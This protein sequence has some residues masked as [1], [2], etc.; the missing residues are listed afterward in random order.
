MWL[1]TFLVEVTRIS[2]RL[3]QIA[4]V[5][6]P[7]LVGAVNPHISISPTSG[8]LGVT[9]FFETYTGFTPNGG[10]TEYDTYPNGGINIHTLTANNSGASS[11]SFV[12]QSQTGNYSAYAVDNASGI[13]SNTITYAVHVPAST[14]TITSIAPGSPTASSGNQNVAV[15]GSQFQSGLTVTVGFPN[16]G[17]STLSGSQIVNVTASSFGMAINFN[18]IAGSYSIRVNNP[19]GGQSNTYGFN[20]GAAASTPT[21]TSISP[22][23]VAVNQPTTVTVNGSNFQSGFSAAVITSVGTYPIASAG[24]MFISSTQVKVQV[25][26]GGTPPF[27]ATLQITDPGRLSATGT[28]QVIT[29]GPATGTIRANPST[30]QVPAVNGTCTISLIWTTQN[31]SAA[32]IWVTAAVG[33]P[34]PITTGLNGTQSIPWIQAAPQKYV[35]HLYD[36]SAGTQGTEL[37]NVPVAASGPAMG[38]TSS[39]VSV[40]PTRNTP[41][42]TFTVLGSGLAP[43]QATIFVQA[44]GGSPAQVGQVRAGPDGSFNNFSYPTQTSSGIGA[45]TV[46]AVDSGGATSS[47]G[48]FTL[49]QP[50]PASIPSC[51]SNTTTSGCNGDPINT[52]TGNYT[53]QH[54]DLTIAGRGLSFAFTRTYNSQS[55]A[56]GPIGA[57]W[58]H[59]YMASLAQNSD[60]SIT[61][62]TPDGQEL[63]FDLIGSS[64]VS[65]FNGVYSTLQAPSSGAFV[66]TTKNQISYRFSNSQLISVSDRNGNTIQLSYSNGILTAITD[67]VG[68]HLVVSADPSG[69]I[70]AIVDPAGRSVQ[71]QYDGTGNLI[72]FTDANGGKFTYAYNGSHQMLTAADALNNTF[73]T[74]TYDS[75]GHVTSQADGMGNLWTYVYDSKSLV[76]TITDPNGNVSSHLHDASFE[77]L[78][79]TDTF[80]ISDLYQ[81]DALGNRIWVQDRNGNASQ[82]N[83]DLN[84]NVIAATDA[85]S[86]V[87]AAA[88]DVQNNPLSRT[89]ALGNQTTFS[90]DSK[91]NLVASI[92]PLG[93]KMTFS[94]DSYGELI[95]KTDAQS[96]ATHYVYDNSGNLTQLIDPIGNKTAYGYDVLGRRTSTTDANGF[97]TNTT[98][99]AN[100]NI[101]GVIDP[102]NNKTQ[103]GYDGNSNRV[104]VI[105]PRGKVTVYAY[106]G[107]YKLITTTDVLGNK[108]S[109]TYD[110]LRNLASVTDQRGNTTHYG[111][112]SENRLTSTI[113]PLGNKSTYVYDAVG[114]RAQLRD[115]LGNA[116]TYVYDS[117][118]RLVST[119]D[120]LGNKATSA[121]DAVGH[122]TRK[123]DQIGNST[124]YSYDALG[125]QNSMLDAAG[126]VVSFQYDKVGNRIQITDARG[127]VT[128]FTF[129]GLNRFLTTT[130]PLGNVTTNQY[131]AVGNLA[132]TIDGNGNS[133]NYQYDADRRQV[134]VIY[135]TSG[136]IRYTYDASGNRIQ[137]IDL[138]GTSI[139]SYDDLNRLQ[140]YTNPAGG[141]FHSATTPRRIGLPCNIQVGNRFNMSTMR[142]IAFPRSRTGTSLPRPTLMMRREKS[143]ES[144]TRTR[145]QAST[146]M[147]PWGRTSAFGTTAERLCSIWRR[148]HGH[149]MEIQAPVISQAS[150]RRGCRLRAFPMCITTRVS[151]PVR[152]TALLSRTGTVISRRRPDSADRR[153][154][155]MI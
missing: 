142:T 47:T 116:T 111:Y 56:Q 139:Y 21:I 87:Q 27:T 3:V 98:Y 104:K 102:L 97:T 60:N 96:N 151:S 12:L 107:N 22:N 82:Y 127:K 31:A 44:S 114:N 64:Y 101:V 150:P 131:D 25:T 130:D 15:F 74:N 110:K 35:F 92:D 88:Y 46:W 48:S 45:Y 84:G 13:H 135:S 16:G 94:Y 53:Y 103:Y 109:N 129:D 80:G 50:T 117:L 57:G 147:T 51:Q 75:L 123:I 66:L 39:I 6:S 152:H 9:S 69:R 113:D 70:T 23:S 67:T 105:D 14:P 32:Q 133:K 54:T 38:T 41:G 40:N 43:G 42:S 68:R 61:I 5:L 118:N 85:Q 52:A 36:Y 19:D 71:Y 136:S 106:D 30:C 37:A 125:R 81:Y 155:H 24:L 1:R 134:G 140:N 137:M 143:L 154:T 2:S 83:Y 28:F 29:A 20:V 72:A 126:G 78:R 90:H 26:V 63:I 115:P 33:S 144:A 18:G 49:Y 4:L 128:Q 132:Q 95:A 11:S 79:A 89:D 77:L 34:E 17:S 146:P 55:G 112:D 93:N 65:R 120:A 10:I 124:M 108:T 121:F 58:T 8:T 122:L 119:K 76:T 7:P 148:P 153:P 145:S 141:Y 91:G 138:V 86:Q 99:D 59:S 73:L 149:R 100:T 62:H